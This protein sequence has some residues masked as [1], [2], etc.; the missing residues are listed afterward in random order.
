M[1]RLMPCGTRRWQKNKRSMNVAETIREITRTHL[2]ED[3]GVALGQCLTAVGWVG[4]TV[5]ELTQSDGLIELPMSDVANGGVAVGLALAGRRPI[6]IVRYQGF[7]W[8]NA[9][10]ILNYAAK[11]KEMWNVPCPV[12]VRSIAM[13][14]AIGP[15]ASGSHH[16]IYMRMPGVAVVAP[17]TPGEYRA[18]WEYY[19]AHTDPVCV[20]EHR[21]SFAI[22]YEMPDVIHPKADV[23]LFPISSTRLGAIEAQ[24]AL[25]AQGV[26][27]NIVHL[28]WLKPFLA[29]DR[30]TNALA[31]SSGRGLVLDGDF[32]NGTAK[33]IAFDI[34]HA[35]PGA[36]MDVMGLEDRVTGFAPQF[37]NVPPT[38]ER[39]AAKVRE[40]IA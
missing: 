16:G 12:F 27:C 21:K 35:A 18:A 32:A 6:Y 29:D 10:S 40:M 24:K 33:Q 36:R 9:I 30:I 5:P 39:I 15:V 3:N 28:V 11:S 8:Y 17:M 14:G 37:D 4:G 22:D 34:M 38:A 20:S 2:K 23:T 1:P 13:D 19:M 31:A 7:Q 26:T 25:M